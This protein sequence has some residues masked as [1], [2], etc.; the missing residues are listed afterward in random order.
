[1]EFIVIPKLDRKRNKIWNTIGFETVEA[2]IDA[3]RL[4]PG[5]RWTYCSGVSSWEA[6]RTERWWPSPPPVCSHCSG[7]LFLDLKQKQQ[8]CWDDNRTYPITQKK[9]KKNHWIPRW[10]WERLQPTWEPKL[11]EWR[12]ITNRH[13]FELKISAV[14]WLFFFCDAGQSQ[15]DFLL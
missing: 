10:C 11:D 14:F 15:I 5:G 7:C 12:R 3:V 13:R 9:K 6:R 2:W 8:K 1:M 4:P